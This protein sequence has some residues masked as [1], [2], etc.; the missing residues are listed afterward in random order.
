MLHFDNRG[1]F[2]KFV[3]EEILLTHEATK[4]LGISSQRLH[5]LVQS[6][7]L[8]PLKSTRS[9]SLFLKSDL[10]DRKFELEKSY[11]TSRLSDK[12]GG[13]NS[14]ETINDAVNYFTL[15]ALFKNKIKK[16]DPIYDHL[17]TQVNLTLP[18]VDIAKDI[19]TIT[20]FDEKEILFESEKVMKGFKTLKEDDYIVKIGSELYPDLLNKTDHA[21]VFLFMRGNPNLLNFKA[22]SIVGTRNP[23]QNGVLRAKVLAEKLGLHRIVV[24]SG[25][26]RGIDTAA[27]NGALSRRNPTISVIGTPI[28]KVYPKEN[29]DLQRSIE[30][31]GL[32]ISQ[33]APSMSVQRWNFPMRNA[34][35]SGISLATVIIEAGETSGSLIQAD[36]ALKQGRMVFIPQSAVDN[37]NLMWPKKYVQRK[38]AFKFSTIDELLEILATHNHDLFT[39]LD[40]NTKTSPAN[41]SEGSVGYVHKND[42]S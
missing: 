28:T 31:S 33:F 19:S 2:E 1:E 13:V 12:E 39:T 29:E 8:T 10:Y 4:Y 14:V 32:V 26:A 20:G 6:G 40:Q 30:E 3:S 16:C 23:S 36:Y 34:I 24:A 35:M 22:I 42:R 18:T 7:K 25:L 41:I 27:H 37:E 21:P 11:G 17:A 15:L 9:S 38:G 5:Q